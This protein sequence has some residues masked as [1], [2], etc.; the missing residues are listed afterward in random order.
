[1]WDKREKRW[2]ASL[3]HGGIYIVCDR[4]KTFEE[5]KAARL[6]AEEIVFAGNSQHKHL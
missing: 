5:A 3:R 1:M 4:F 6:A 2:R